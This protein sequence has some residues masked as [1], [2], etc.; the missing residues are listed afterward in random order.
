MII[1][2]KIEMDLALSGQTPEVEAV[3]D[4]KYSRNLEVSLLAAGTPWEVPAGTYAVVRY[5]K[6]DGTG[7]SYDT[8][9]DGSA[10]C[11]I[12]GSVV[13]VALAP[14]VCTASGL[15]RLAIGLMGLEAEINTF[16]I[17]L[18]V[19]RNPGID[20]VSEDYTNMTAYVKAFGWAPYMYLSTDENGWVVSV[21]PL[22]RI[23]ETTEEILD[24]I[25]GTTAISVVK[26]EDAVSFT[27]TLANGKRSV[28][29]I[30]LDEYGYPASIVTDG[31]ACPVSWEGF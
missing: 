8:L 9:P 31:V 28:S 11:S 25:L 26:G 1:T 19:H 2:S 23:G 12:S 30:V 24:G 18:V 6:P 27:S 13:T 15:V 4:D 3:Q 20:A 17:N 14:Q 22:E 5:M 10:A 29:E 16:A 21:D 7:G